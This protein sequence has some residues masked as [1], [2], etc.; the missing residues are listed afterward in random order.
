MRQRQPSTELTGSFVGSLPVERHQRGR[1]AG[2]AGNL[3]APFV[4]ANARDLYQVVSAVDFFCKPMLVHVVSAA[5]V[6]RQESNEDVES[7]EH[8]NDCYGRDKRKN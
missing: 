5:G 6:D 7:E 3:R 2:D 8:S 1:S 4:D